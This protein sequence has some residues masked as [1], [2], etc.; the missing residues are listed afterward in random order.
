MIELTLH[1]RILPFLSSELDL[2]R[3]VAL[4]GPMLSAID[5]AFEDEIEDARDRGAISHTQRQRVYETDLIVRA[6][7]R[8]TRDTVYVV[9][10]AS[11]TIDD[12]DIDR[13]GKTADALRQVFPDVEV[14]PAVYGAAVAR[15]NAALADQTGVKI[16]LAE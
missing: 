4:I 14:V 5:H 2:R 10:E 16:F 6:R 1:S 8:A 3:V 13:A 15:D 12:D 9:V 7:S 11:F